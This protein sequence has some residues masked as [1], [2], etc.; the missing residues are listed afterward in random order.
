[1]PI[2]HFSSM[3]TPYRDVRFQLSD[4]AAMLATRWRGAGN[5]NLLKTILQLI[6]SLLRTRKRSML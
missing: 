3:L 4:R 1:M 5:A 6:A 2:T